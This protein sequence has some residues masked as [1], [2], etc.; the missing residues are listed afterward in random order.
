MNYSVGVCRPSSHER[1]S[2]SIEI[3]FSWADH[4][5]DSQMRSPENQLSQ[6]YSAYH[7]VRL[8]NTLDA[9][10]DISILMH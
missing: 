3:L 4:V 9:T 10:V 2:L 5:L 1:G 7:P 8:E 6:E